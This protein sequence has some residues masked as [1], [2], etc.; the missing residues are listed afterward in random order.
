MRFA[1]A[2]KSS[3]KK[4]ATCCGRWLMALQPVLLNFK[5]SKCRSRTVGTTV[6]LLR[7]QF[8]PL[9]RYDDGLDRL[10]PEGKEALREFENF[11]SPLVSA[12]W[13]HQQFPND[14]L[15]PKI[16]GLAAN[17][18]DCSLDQRRLF[19]WNRPSLAVNAV[20]AELSQGLKATLSHLKSGPGAKGGRKRSMARRLMIQSIIRAWTTIGR[21]VSTGSKSDFMKF[22][23]AITSSTGWSERGLPTAVAKAVKDWRNRAQ[24]KTR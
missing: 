18:E 24:K 21:K 6:N 3:L 4:T 17:F 20:L 14:S 16:A 22:V 23:A 8:R 9:R 13:L 10:G 19:I 1:K 12:R 15:A 11:L 5:R 7:A 2:S